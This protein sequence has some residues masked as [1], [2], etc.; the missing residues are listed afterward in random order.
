MVK[1]S[2]KWCEAGILIKVSDNGAGMEEA[3]E[4]EVQ[5]MI[6]DP[7]ERPDNRIGLRNVHQRLK[8]RYQ[9]NGLIIQTRANEGT[10][11]CYFI[12]IVKGRKEEE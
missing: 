3:R 1:I 9:T 7:M 5:R 11:I 8:M 2:V 4:E 6:N 10:T 12:P